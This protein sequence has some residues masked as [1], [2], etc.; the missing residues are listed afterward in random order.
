MYIR[1]IDIYEI[2]KLLNEAYNDTYNCDHLGVYVE[3]N[4]NNNNNEIM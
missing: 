1:Y 3:Y 2:V 4:D